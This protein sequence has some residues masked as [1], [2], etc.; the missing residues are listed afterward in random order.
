[1]P[2]KLD[3]KILCGCGQKY[4]FYVYPQNGRMPASVQCPVCGVDGTAAANEFIALKLKTQPIFLELR[5]RPLIHVP[6]VENAAKVEE[7]EA[8]R[9]RALDA[10]RRAEQAQAVMRG[11]LAPYLAQLL[12][13][14]MIREL[15]AQRR[16]LLMVQ[17]EVVMEIAAMIRR[18]DSAQTPI[19]E[20]LRSYEARIQ[21]LEAELA[22]RN[23]ENRELLKLK[24]E[25]VR[26]QLEA[27]R[28]HNRMDF[29]PN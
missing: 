20:R 3:V 9:Q 24:I 14:T 7:V 13:E 16:E 23:E 6:P 5:P 18:L 26:R 28:I 17:E 12:K 25:L 21:E 1:M 10:E 29:N 8:L 4:A 15:A 27:E 22:A 19:R 2:V 11:G